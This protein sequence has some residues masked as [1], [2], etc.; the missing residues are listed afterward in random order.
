MQPTSETG[1]KAG[2]D[3]E[4]GPDDTLRGVRRFPSALCRGPFCSGFLGSNWSDSWLE[5]V[6]SQEEKGTFPAR[7]AFPLQHPD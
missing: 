1:I 5:G 7:E 2:Q 3:L 4:G 6:Y